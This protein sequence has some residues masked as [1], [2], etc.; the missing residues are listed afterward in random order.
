[1]SDSARFILG[2][3]GHSGS[4]KT[5]LIEK[6]LPLMN[7]RGLRVN[8]IKSTHLDVQIEPE[9]KDSARLR[10]AGAADV[11]LSTPMRYMLVHELRGAPVPQLPDLI[12]RMLPAD[13]T[14]VEGY[15]SAQIPR[16]E[17]YRRES[18]Q[19]PLY[20][21]DSSIIAV[22]S[23]L[24]RPHDFPQRTAWLDLNAPEKICDWLFAN[25]TLPG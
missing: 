2:F 1:M 4:G 11:I 5:T 18:G 8:V 23:D 13:V 25:R 6:L 17:V 12:E 7:A 10:L 19:D 20:L 24:P 21:R 3:V 15:K 16:L 14:L 22:I 9:H